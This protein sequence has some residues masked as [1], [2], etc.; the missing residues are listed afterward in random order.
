LIAALDRALLQIV[1]MPVGPQ[2]HDLL[3]QIDADAAA[4]ADC[5][6]FPFQRLLPLVEMFNEILRNQLDAL[7]GPDNRFQG[8]PLRL[9]FLFPMLLLAFSDVL[10][11]WPA[12]DRKQ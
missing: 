3:V 9:E 10:E 7:F 5:H 2:L 4:H 8:S 6:R 12:C 11:I 1:V